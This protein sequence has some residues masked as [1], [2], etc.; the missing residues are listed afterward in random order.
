LPILLA[1]LICGLVGVTVGAAELLGRYRDHP[2]ALASCLSGWIYVLLNGAASLAFLYLANSYHWTFGI[3]GSSDSLLSHVLVASFGAMAL[4]RT[5]LFN[6]KVDNEVVPIGPSVIL[7]AL[8]NVADRGVDRARAIKRSECASTIMRPISFVRAQAALPTFCLTLLQ[9]PNVIEQQKLRDAV[10]ALHENADMA[11][12]LKSMSLGLLLMNIVGPKGLKAAVEALG[13]D[14][15]VEDPNLQP[16]SAR[17]PRR[18][19]RSVAPV[20]NTLPE[21]EPA[22]NPESLPDSQ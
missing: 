2:A 9:N 22:G 6:L 4:L 15:K 11:D 16:S 5:S 1:Y 21:G 3:K 7:V 17:P 10:Q 8:L 14:I 19:R 18:K 13:D 12:V 20:Q